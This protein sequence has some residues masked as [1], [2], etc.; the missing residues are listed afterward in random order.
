MAKVYVSADARRKAFRKLKTHRDNQ[1]C[2]DCPTRNPTWASVT[3]GIFVCLDC[4]GTHRS[5]GTHISF[6]RSVEMDEWT[7]PQIDAMRLGGNK[8]AR[9]FFQQ[10]GIADLK[11]TKKYSIRGA[12]LYKAHLQR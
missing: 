11:T 1:V 5:L 6:V 7:Q 12:Q 10:H 2:F 8:N 9:A 4:S 3:F